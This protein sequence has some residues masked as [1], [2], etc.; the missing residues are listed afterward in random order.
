MVS[1][2]KSE[3]I[4]YHCSFKDEKMVKEPEIVGV[5]TGTTI[6][7]NLL[8]RDLETRRASLNP[9]E[10]KKKVVRL[11]SHFALHYNSIKFSI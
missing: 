2:H 5:P 4:G 6:T 11:V 3:N 8:F 7:A 10:E 1:K 9:G